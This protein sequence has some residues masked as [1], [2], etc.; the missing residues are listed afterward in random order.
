MNIHE[1]P[2]KG[3][4]SSDHEV[5]NSQVDQVEVDRRSH[6]LVEDH[7]VVGKGGCKRISLRDVLCALADV[8]GEKNSIGIKR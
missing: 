6:R 7:L 1:T 8:R 4:P 2:V 3:S 5:S